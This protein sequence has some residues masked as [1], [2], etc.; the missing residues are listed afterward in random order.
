[1][2]GRYT[3][4]NLPGEET[5]E[6]PK[7]VATHGPFVPFNIG[8]TL[9]PATLERLVDIIENLKTDT[10]GYYHDAG[11][12][13]FG[14]EVIASPFRNDTAYVG[15][16]QGRGVFE[17]LNQAFIVLSLFNGLQLHDGEK[18]FS[19]Y[20]AHEPEHE[21]AM[22]QTLQYLYPTP[23]DPWCVV[24][25]FIFGSKKS[26]DEPSPYPEQRD[27]RIRSDCVKPGSNTILLEA[28]QPAKAYRWLVWDSLALT[29]DLRD[30]IWSLGLDEAPDD[31]TGNAFDEFDDT[32]PFNIDFDVESMGA[33]DFP[34]QL[35]DNALPQVF[36]TFDLTAEEADRDL[37]LDLDTLYATHD[38]IDS[39]TM[40]VQ[41]NGQG[42]TYTL[43]IRKTWP[44][45]LTEKPL[46]LIY[47]VL[48][49]NLDSGW[50]LLVNN[51]ERG[52]R[53]DADVR[54]MVNALGLDNALV[55]EAG[56]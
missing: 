15:A 22:Q 29:T 45:P 26:E 50:D 48:D 39:F 13:P 16:D 10:A 51:I 19:A 5:T 2:V 7:H 24:G 35:N 30:P 20:A 38:D 31:Y 17:T 8:P 47:A 23:S 53:D 42:K 6:T 14:F 32:L 28:V 9:S 52:V 18:P 21:L 25:D 37:I 12:H 36:I 3:P 11:S 43:A 33:G 55:Y 27:V 40:R 56:P 4:P 46:V 44:E 1:M 54:L 34:F 41:V 49:N